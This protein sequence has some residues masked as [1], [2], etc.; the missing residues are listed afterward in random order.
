M[1][2]RRETW[3]PS[4]K[5]RTQAGAHRSSDGQGPRPGPDDVES[6][7]A[8]VLERGTL[9]QEESREKEDGEPDRRARERH[10]EPLPG[11]CGSEKWRSRPSSR[12]ARLV[13]IVPGLLY[14]EGHHGIDPRG[15]PGGEVARQ[16]RH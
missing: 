6:V 16:Q 13:R 3:A 7:R 12:Q 1:Q 11:K 4:I 9:A 8:D 15:A 2:A 14:S 10:P 5:G